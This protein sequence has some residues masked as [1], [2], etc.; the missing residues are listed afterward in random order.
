MYKKLNI[1]IWNRFQIFNFYYQLTKIFYQYRSFRCLHLDYFRDDKALHSTKTT[2]VLNGHY[3]VSQINL[4]I[5]LFL[6]K[7]IFLTIKEYCTTF[8]KAYN[9]RNLFLK[10]CPVVQSTTKFLTSQLE[11]IFSILI[12]FAYNHFKYVRRH[13]RSWLWKI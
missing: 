7:L 9:K 1:Q 11:V 4:K 13:T 12:L 8:L 2:W 3:I 5:K 10:F 6:R